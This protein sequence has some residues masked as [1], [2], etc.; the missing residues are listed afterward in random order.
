MKGK[1]LGISLAILGISCLIL[2]FV[3]MNAAESF[4]HLS[5]LLT[6]GICG[7][8]V[9]FTGIWLL[10]RKTVFDPQK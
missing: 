7:A 10:P 4:K 6:G 2:A 3:Y 8:I 1:I 5:V 9:F